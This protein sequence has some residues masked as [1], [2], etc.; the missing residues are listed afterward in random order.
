MTTK[1]KEKI[2]AEAMRRLYL[3]LK[4]ESFDE[5]S[6]CGSI[7]RFDMSL[8]LLGG[9]MFEKPDWMKGQKFNSFVTEE[10]FHSH[11]YNFIIQELYQLGKSYKDNEHSN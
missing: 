6:V 5:M 2:K 3:W 9:Y 7:R 11:E 1:R 10:E 8:G 4:N